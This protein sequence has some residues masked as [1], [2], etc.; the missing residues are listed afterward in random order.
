MPTGIKTKFP[1]WMPTKSSLVSADKI[2]A[3]DSENGSEP[4]TIS[5]GELALS[6]STCVTVGTTGSWARFICDWT[7]DEVQI[8]QAIDY[9]GTLWGWTIRFLSGTYNIGTITMI[10]DIAIVWD[11]T[12]IIKAK[13]ALNSYMIDMFDVT[14]NVSFDWIIFDG[15]SSNQSYGTTVDIIGRRAT[16]TAVK[17]WVKVM[18]CTFK[19]VV[20]EA[21]NADNWKYNCVIAYNDIQDTMYTGIRSHSNEGMVVTW[22]TINCEWA[23]F[24]WIFVDGRNNHITDNVITVDWTVVG[25]K[26]ENDWWFA[27]SYNTV[28]NNTVIGSG[29]RAWYWISLIWS[30][31]KYNTFT[32][33]T[34]KNL[35]SGYH[36]L[37]TLNTV[38]WWACYD[39]T[40]WVALASVDSA[41]IISWYLVSWSAN[42]IYNNSGTKTIVNNCIFST[43]WYGYR[44]VNSADNN[45][46]DGNIFDTITTTAITVLWVWTIQ[47]NN[48]TV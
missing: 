10:N 5:Y 24:C 11:K 16:S 36:Q 4:C 48:L 6:I 9:L 14:E 38:N 13:N 3:S 7:A 44:E 46:L 27:V 41:N 31:V 25:I 2:M 21:V 22:N 19:N 15:N 40:Y 28:A 35:I 30:N 37:A 47:S 18:N 20:Y 33:N 32:G 43:C 29:T 42:W 8:Q 12:V 17:T 23:L 45:N 34:F 39:C 1:S 26:F